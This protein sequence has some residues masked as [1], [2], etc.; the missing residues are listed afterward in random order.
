MGHNRDLYPS[1][2][3]NKI[4]MF[5]RLDP[6]I[7][8]N[9]Q[10]RSGG[11]LTAEQLDTFERDGFFFFPGFFNT[12]EIRA[13]I[14]ELHRLSADPVIRASSSVILEPGNSEVRSIFAIHKVSPHFQRLA[15]DPRIRDCAKQ[16]LGSDVYV[17]QSRINYKPG[18]KGKGF[19][20][21]SGFET[22]H[23]DADPRLA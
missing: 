7:H 20:W 22:W 17:H 6:V 15:H 3:Q 12:N 14:D 11:P 5:R 13:C 23:T 18:F 10:T 21:H 16:L 9:A 4:P 8:G 19:N 2:T 1:R